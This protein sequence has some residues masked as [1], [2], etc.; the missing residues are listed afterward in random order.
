MSVALMLSLSCYLRPGEM[1]RLTAS[2]LVPP[3]PCV[4]KHWCL[5]LFPSEN[6]ARSKTGTSDD[7]IVVDSPYL[8]SWIGP[9]LREL[10]KN[11]D[12]C[13]IWPFSYL[14]Y[15]AEFK[16]SVKAMG[17]GPL[18]PYQARHSGPSI[19]RSRLWR[20]LEECQKRGRWRSSKSVARYEKGGRLGVFWNHL[21]AEVRSRLE[22]CE[23]HLDDLVLSRPGASKVTLPR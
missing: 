9:V 20:S 12:K 4:S 10:Q 7:S 5:L 18:V 14:Q 23:R 19:D 22:M 1:M 16:K 2:S 15:L 17:V 3:S 21:A 11:G 13:C 6:V 8:K